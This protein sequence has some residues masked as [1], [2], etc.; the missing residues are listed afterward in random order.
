MSDQLFSSEFSSHQ[1]DGVIAEPKYGISQ[2]V[3]LTAIV[4]GTVGWLW[5][6]AWAATHVI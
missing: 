5:L 2:I 6:I 4:A 3:Y 1:S